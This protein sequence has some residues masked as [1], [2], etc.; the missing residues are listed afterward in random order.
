MMNRSN[1]GIRSEA[2]MWGRVTITAGASLM[3]ATSLMADTDPFDYLPKTVQVTGVVRDF[4]DRQVADGHPDFNMVPV[5][6]AAHYYGIVQDYLDA[7]GNPVF[8]S[9]GYKVLTEWR[10]AQGRNIIQPKA[11]MTARPGDMAGAIKNTTGG[12]VKSADSFSEWYKDVLGQNMSGL[13]TITLNRQENSNFYVFDDDLDTQFVELEGFYNPNG[14]F[15][16]AQG[17]NKNWSF[18][19]ELDLEFKYKQG[20]GQVFTFGG[21]DD[22]WVFVDGKLVIDIGGV[23]GIV[24][25][26]VEM[27]RLN[28]LADGQKYQ[29]KVFFA[30]RYKPRSNFRIETTLNFED[31]P[32]PPS[33][34]PTYD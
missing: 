6:G 8:K 29:M 15:N 34:S 5:D 33:I 27:D 16:N 10:D 31:P 25:Q 26:T 13:L 18:T 19:Y 4:R 23:H 12:A 3:L 1:P 22:L 11:Y 28:W 17:G 2:H 20:S 21:D 24:R 14:K 9:R 7:E 30:E 32:P